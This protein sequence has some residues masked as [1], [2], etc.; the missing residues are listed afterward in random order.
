MPKTMLTT[1]YDF[2]TGTHYK[3][4]MLLANVDP[5]ESVDTA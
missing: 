4:R 5:P 3:A 1:Y 2:N